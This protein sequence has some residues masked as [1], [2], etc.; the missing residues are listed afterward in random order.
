MNNPISY[1]ADQAMTIGPKDMLK[2]SLGVVLP[3]GIREHIAS[4]DLQGTGVDET[5]L[6]V[7]YFK[8]GQSVSTIVNASDINTGELGSEFHLERGDTL[9]IDTSGLHHNVDMPDDEYK[10]WLAWAVMVCEAGN[11]RT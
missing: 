8:N 1:T 10:E 4:V 5:Y 3:E 11:D 9:K 7:F 2:L 6:A